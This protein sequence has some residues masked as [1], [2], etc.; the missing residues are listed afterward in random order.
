M[1]MK[2]RDWETVVKDL[3]DVLIVRNTGNVPTY[4]MRFYNEVFV[5]CCK[6][7]CKTITTDNLKKTYLDDHMTLKM[8]VQRTEIHMICQ[9]IFI[10][11]SLKAVLVRSDILFSFFS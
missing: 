1:R 7:Q 4:K 5:P 3:S 6:T 11:I 2:K 8:A 9:E 10:I